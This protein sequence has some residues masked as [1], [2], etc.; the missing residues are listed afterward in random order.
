MPDRIWQLRD[1]LTAYDA[2]YVALAELLNADLVT[3]D[4]RLAHAPGNH[5]RTVLLEP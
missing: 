3:T 5:A 4:A 2:S 1:T